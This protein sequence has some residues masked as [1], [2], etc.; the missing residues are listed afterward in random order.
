MRAHTATTRRASQ[1]DFLPEARREPWFLPILRAA[2]PL[3]LSI[4][5]ACASTPTVVEERKPIVEAPKVEQQPT[6][7]YGAG[8]EAFA[9]RQFDKA[10]SLYDAFLQKEPR[11]TQ[12]RFNRALTLAELGK[13]DQA[14]AAYEELV[15]N[16]PKSSDAVINLGAVYRDKGEIDRGVKV[17]EAFLKDNPFDSR[18]LN[19]LVALYRD[20]KDYGKAI[21]AV[22]KLLMRDKNNI[23]AYKNLALVY[24]DQKKFKLTQTILENAQGMAKTAG[25]KDPDISVNLGLLYLATG[26]N[27]RAM[28]AFKDA[29]GIAPAHP[30]ANY[31]IAALALAHRDYDLAA[32]GFK[33][34]A[35]KWPNDYE[36]TASLGFA[37]QGL[38]KLQESEALL[39]KALEMKRDENVMLQLA[40]VLQ[41]EERVD[42]AIKLVDE[43]IALKGMTCGPDDYEG[44]CGRKKGLE[45]MK[46]MASRPPEQEE[47][48][49]A[50]GVDIF[51]QPEG[52]VDP[53]AEGAAP[54]GAPVPSPEAAAPTDPAAAT[55]DAP[56]AAP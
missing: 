19:N 38:G 29:I 34:A 45:T 49:K 12:A 27:G 30:L 13:H 39:K 43:V 16:D 46:Q 41:M 28:A 20:K 32:K 14:L 17:Y 18:V 5:A 3:A 37:Y 51:N 21:Q 33:I 23:D 11:H 50:T 55:P 56:K 26:D 35:D 4:S 1:I 8:N 7:Q 9:A 6:D 48:P 2:Y 53:G 42:D 52:A 15:A 36:V 24:F 40:V 10:L 22:R 44:L 31:N 25:I 47:K 54:E